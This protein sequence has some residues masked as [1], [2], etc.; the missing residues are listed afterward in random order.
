MTCMGIFNT[1]RVLASSHSSSLT[2]LRLHQGEKYPASLHVP[3]CLDGLSEAQ[4][5]TRLLET[6]R[7]K[8]IVSKDNKFIL[9]RNGLTKYLKDDTIKV[10]RYKLDGGFELLPMSDRRRR[11]RLYLNES[12]PIQGYSYLSV[13]LRIYVSQN[14]E[15]VRKGDN[16]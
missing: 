10:G 5:V 2:K 14:Y 6:D 3:A 1:I 15:E 7:E 13:H 8:G 9:L 12:F 16:Y 4:V 11:T